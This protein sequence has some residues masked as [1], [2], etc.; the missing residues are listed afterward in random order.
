MLEYVLPDETAPTQI[1][2]AG[3]G[4][5]A[6]RRFGKRETFPLLLLNY[7]AA[8]LDDWDPESPTVLP[9]SATLSFSTILEWAVRPARRRPGSQQ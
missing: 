3:S 7:F 6:Y 8:N 1:A 4:R 2:Q 5:V 9:N